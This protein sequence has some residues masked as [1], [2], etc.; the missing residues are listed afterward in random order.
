M[1]K[2]IK[3]TGI[4]FLAVLLIMAFFKNTS[5]ENFQDKIGQVLRTDNVNQVKSGIYSSHMILV[6]IDTQKIICG[7]AI[8]EKTYPA[9]L[10][11]I[12]TAV[13]AIEKLSDL[14]EKV[15]LPESIF[16]KLYAE[17]S[18]MAG[19]LPD[20]A[21]P[22][23]DLLYGTL[24][25]SGGDAACALACHISGSEEAF[26]KL[27]NKK[28]TKLGMKNT[29]FINATGLHDPEHFT[30]VEDMA[31]LLQ[32]ALK[33]ETFEKI[34]TAQ[35]YSTSPS[36]RHNDGITFYSTLF[37]KIG[38]EQFK[39][40]RI[41]GGKTGYTRE[42]GLCLASLAEKEGERYI[43]IT[44]GANGNLETAQYNISDA[45]NIY[46]LYTKSQ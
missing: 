39:G 15:I 13:V 42:A 37:Q 2:F 22:A 16:E 30:T 3:K 7:K 8:K 34:F 25:P 18:S 28:A 21:V 4:V 36:N 43:L 40:G 23:R 10:T 35:K 45:I 19:F 33:N 5:F 11:K 24:L 20:E 12:M 38:S 26:V 46:T 6:D 9:S 1:K 14:N 29:K 41:I 31:V 17:N 44:T 32:Y 27:M